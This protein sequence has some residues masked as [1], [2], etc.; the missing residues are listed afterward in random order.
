[1][2]RAALLVALAGCVGAVSPKFADRPIVTASDDARPIKEPKE[3]PYYSRAYLADA[4]VFRPLYEPLDPRE[5]SLAEDV[6]ALDEVPDSTWFTNRLGIRAVTPEEAVTGVDSKGAPV[7]PFTIIHAKKG[8][9]NPGFIA[10]DSRGVKYLVKFDTAANPGQQT[11]TDA[12][13]NRIL[14]TVGYHTPADYVVNFRRDELTIDPELRTKKGIDDRVVDRMLVDAAH[15]SDGAIRASVSQ[16]L[17]GVPKNGWAHAGKRGDD[18]N[19]RVPHEHRR[20]VRG[21][22]VLAAWLNHTDMKEDNTLD[23]YEGK[24]GEGHI[25]HYLV[26]FG[27]AFAGHQDENDQ[28]QI[29]FEYA[30]DYKA[31][32]KALFAFGLWHRRWEAQRQSP[33]KE[34]GLFSATAFDPKRWKERYP[35]TPFALAD[36]ADHYWGAKLVMKFDRPML[37]AIVK[38]GQFGDPAAEKYVVDTLIARRDAIGRAFLDGVTPLDAIKLTGATLCGVDLARHHG[39]ATDGALVIDGAAIPIAAD[40]A[41]CTTVPVTPGYHLVKVRIR[42]ADHTTPVLEIHYVG[43]AD[44][45]VVG[46]VR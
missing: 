7:L 37:E 17:E 10:K 22:R 12:I 4:L 25:V 46:L 8:G 1:V 41:V 31:Q 39:I 38:T 3:R 9:A 42:R 11:G 20:T 35:Y 18:P 6:N 36:R 24:P 2:R 29:G 23:M 19:D 30:W 33:W 14:W 5:R 44:P 40:G 21:L 43:G 15:R 34:V 16:L 28:A 26:D 32:G 27:E 45:H 13:V